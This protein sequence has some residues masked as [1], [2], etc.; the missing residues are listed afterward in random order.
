MEM[1][2]PTETRIEPTDPVVKSLRRAQVKLQL[3]IEYQMFTVDELRAL[4]TLSDQT[5]YDLIN[6]GEISFV[7]FGKRKIISGDEVKR[8]INLLKG[9]LIARQ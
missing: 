7:P 4:T 6:R 3:P 1:P 5:I 9:G 2:Y 8:L